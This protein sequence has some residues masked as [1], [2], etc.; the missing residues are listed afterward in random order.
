MT[1][2]FHISEIITNAREWVRLEEPNILLVRALLAQ[3]LWYE[4]R[5]EMKSKA[6]L[7]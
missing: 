2:R 1:S 6:K 7:Y 3:R 5:M 4:I